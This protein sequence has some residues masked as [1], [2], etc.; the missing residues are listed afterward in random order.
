MADLTKRF[1]DEEMAVILKRAA[2]LQAAR[3]DHTHSLPE[4]QAIAAQVG[5]DPA[6]VAHVAGA[7]DLATRRPGRGLFPA[8]AAQQEI[9]VEV[10]I[11]TS[12]YGRVLQAIRRV[13]GTQGRAQE[14]F[15]SLEWRTGSERDAL[16]YAVTVTGRPDATHV[17][18]EA[19]FGVSVALMHIAGVAPFMAAVVAAGS[20]LPTEAAIGAAGAAG[21]AI[22]GGIR[23]IWRRLLRKTEATAHDLA[24]EIER[25]VKEIASETPARVAPSAERRLPSST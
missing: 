1:S 21:I 24:R 11:T 7:A 14:V 15:N 10:P 20:L 5:I 12:D 2:T 6:L 13:M 23:M 9:R 22:L 19:D 16:W 4:I 8:S 25:E 17:R 3:D 18:V